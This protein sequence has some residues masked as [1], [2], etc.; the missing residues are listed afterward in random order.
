LT[1]RW[2]AGIAGLGQRCA[3]SSSRRREWLD[4]AVDQFVVGGSWPDCDSAENAALLGVPSADFEV[5]Q[6]LD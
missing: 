2:V 3:S 6:Q 5:A 1:Y 4:V